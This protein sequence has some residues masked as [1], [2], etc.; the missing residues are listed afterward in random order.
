VTTRHDAEGRLRVIPA[1]DCWGLLESQEIARVAWLGAGGVAVV[2]VNHTLADGSLWFRT[3][4][5][6]A[7]GR[8]CGGQRVVVEVDSVD[9]Q[10]R[11]GWSVVVA[12]TAE[13]VAAADVP[14]LVDLRVWPTGSRNLFVRVDSA[15]VS[16]RRLF[17]PATVA[18]STPPG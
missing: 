18:D 2:P 17:G 13:L 6:T 4:P 5:D 1:Y 15:E 11:S 7:L 16:G 3:D 12:G 9:A 10:T 14:E 8:E